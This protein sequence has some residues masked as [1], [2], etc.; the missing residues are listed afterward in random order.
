MNKILLCLICFL[1]SFVVPAGAAE[2]VLPEK[3]R[4]ATYNL[5]RFSGNSKGTHKGG[6]DPAPKEREARDAIAAVLKEVNP[7]ILVVQEIGDE[8]WLE[9][10]R[11]D[12]AA[13]GLTFLQEN[14]QYVFGNDRFNHLA[15]L[16]KYPCETEMWNVRGD[17]LT[18]GFISS[19]F[20]LKNGEPFYVFNVHLKSQISN[21]DDPKSFKRRSREILVL[22]SLI[23]FGV[24]KNLQER[25]DFF[26][27]TTKQ[28]VE[29]GIA[30]AKSDYANN[31]LKT[32]YW[33][34]EKITPQNFVILG[35]FNTPENAP[36][37][38][39]LSK[40][41]FSKRVPAVPAIVNKNC[42]LKTEVGRF[43]NPELDKFTYVI[44]YAY[45]PKKNLRERN[46][47]DY[48]AQLDQIFVSPNVYK[49]AARV[50]A[51]IANYDEAWVGSDHRC[52][53]IDFD[54]SK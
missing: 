17:F 35:D 45:S 54:F 36:E 44:K 16:S 3:F 39:F 46:I 2:K 1:L 33:E 31:K 14:C 12:L 50:P 42:D 10:L 52:V 34:R 30:G 6:I 23:E 40:D 11:Q 9:N 20:K 4:V 7:D 41:N 37:L 32:N 25:K 21:D 27:G 29:Y 28:F 18:R 53:F 19:K 38:A 43:R 5:L 26:A 13:V 47:A 15:V 8:R 48:C 51:T 49:T 24:P 22:R